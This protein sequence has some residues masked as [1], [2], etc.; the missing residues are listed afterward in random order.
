MRDGAQHQRSWEMRGGTAAGRLSDAAW[1]EDRLC[2][3]SGAQ[4]W[5]R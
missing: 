4:L 1:L 3:M 5:K 2:E